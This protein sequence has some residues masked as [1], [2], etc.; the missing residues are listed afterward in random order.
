MKKIIILGSCGSIGTQTLDSLDKSGIEFCIEAISVGSNL[1]IAKKII[2]KYNP[3]LVCTR[4]KEH[5]DILKKEFNCEFVYGDEGLIDVACFKKEENILLVSAL[6]G[7]VGLIPT[8]NAIKIKRDIALANKETLVMAGEIVMDLVKQYGVNLFP[9]DSEHSAIWQCMQG[10][11]YNDVK[12]MI[13]TASGGSLRDLSINQLNDVTKEQVLNHPNWSMGSKI[14]VDSATMMNKGFEV[15]EAHYLFNISYDK[16][17]TIL[18]KQ[19][20]IH[21]MVEFNDGQIKAQIGPHDM[22]LPI[23]YAINYPKRVDMKL[24]SL[25]FVKVRELTFEELK[26][27]RFNCLRLA[28]IAG[29]KGNIFPTVLNAANDT[30]VELFLMDKIKFNQI[31]KII[32]EYLNK[33]QKIDNINIDVILVI[34]KEVREEIYNRYGDGLNV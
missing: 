20:I 25:D 33:Y 22:R 30:C 16:I 4:T 19:S 3:N 5:I 11:D 23:I 2:K 8:V 26:F 29:E 18:H 14:T 24:K 6:V 1:E 27:D 15:I 34:N 17:D 21:S 32:E 13:I 7:S 10:E 9:L 12:K 28:Y 31:D